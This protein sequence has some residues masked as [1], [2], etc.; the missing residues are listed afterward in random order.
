MKLKV[1]MGKLVFAMKE[2]EIKTLHQLVSECGLSDCVLRELHRRGTV[3]KETL[4]L[5]SQR[6]G[7]PINDFVY[8]DEK[9]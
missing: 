2:K 5:L 1:D 8:L 3:S 7:V 6:L 4:W 9:N